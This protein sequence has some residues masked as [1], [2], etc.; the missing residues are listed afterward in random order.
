M[1]GLKIS[2]PFADTLEV[3]F[4]GGTILLGGKVSLLIGYDAISDP[5][6]VVRNFSGGGT[7]VD[8]HDKRVHTME[9]VPLIG[10]LIMRIPL[11]CTSVEWRG[12]VPTAR[13]SGKSGKTTR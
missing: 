3:T 11:D 6:V 5:A 13:D 2:Q 7:F 12:I 1:E 8:S 4:D 10:D 9:F